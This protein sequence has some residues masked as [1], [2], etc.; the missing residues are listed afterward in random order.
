MTKNDT[1]PIANQSLCSHAPSKQLIIQYLPEVYAY[2]YDMWLIYITSRKICKHYF[3]SALCHRDTGP[4]RHQCDSLEC[5]TFNR[6]G[7]YTYI[8]IYN[9]IYLQQQS[10]RKFNWDFY[11]LVH[12]LLQ[13]HPAVQD[14][15]TEHNRSSLCVT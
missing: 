12:R 4:L 1:F 10:L 9:K 3:E 7:F 15:T 6:W 13:E 8:N 14:A 2:L 11:I 5:T